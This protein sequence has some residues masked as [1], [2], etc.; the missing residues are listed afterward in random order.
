MKNLLEELMKKHHVGECNLYELQG[1]TI[2]K[3]KKSGEP[4]KFNEGVEPV[5]ILKYEIKNNSTY[6]TIGIIWGRG[7]SGRIYKIYLYLRKSKEDE[8]K[9]DVLD[10]EIC[11]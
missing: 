6:G 7:C 9:I 1:Q 2:A 10:C 4:W 11:E 5:N 3:Y 8:N